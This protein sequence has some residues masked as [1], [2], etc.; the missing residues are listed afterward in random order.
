MKLSSR[1]AALLLAVSLLASCQEGT[2]T[3]SIANGSRVRL[4][5]ESPTIIRVRAVPRGAWFSYKPSLCVVP[6]EGFKEVIITKEGYNVCMSTGVITASVDRRTGCVTFTDSLGNVLLSEAGREFKPIRVDKTNAYTVRQTFEP[7]NEGFYGLGQHQADEWDYKG[8]NEELYQYNTKISIP[9]VVSSKRYGILWDSYSFCRWGDPRPYA[10]LGEVFT[11]RDKDGVKGA[12][13]GTYI[14]ARGDIL[15]RR[16]TSLA[17]EYLRTPECDKVINAPDGFEFEGS[18]VIYEGTLEPSESGF[19]NFYLYYAGY[20]KVFVEGRQVMPEIWR[21]A[22]N[23]NGR[24]FELRMEAGKPVPVRIEWIPDGG[25]SYCALRVLS[26]VDPE[27]QSAMSWWGEMQDQID[28]YFIAGESIDGVIAG[29]RTLTGKSPIVP[30]WAMGYWQSR[31]RYTSQDQIVGTLKE[32]RERHIPIDNIVQDWQYW[33]D[34]GWGS[35]E[36]DRTR[37]PDPKKMVKDIHAMNGRY[38]ISVWP[39]FYVG[40]E[41]FDEL[42]AKGWIYQTAVRD[43]VEDWLGYQ[44]SFYDAYA[45]GARKLFWKQMKRHLYG[46]GVD[47]WWMDASEPNIHDCTDMDY[48]KAMCGPTALG[49]STKYFNAYAL[50]NAQAIYEGQRATHDNRR[51]FLLTRNGF[52]GLQ[53]YSTASW[54]GDI[55]TRWEDMKAQISAGLNYSISGIPFWGQDIG[56]FSVEKRFMQA[57]ALYNSTGR[58]GDDLLEWREMQARWHE[59]GV[60]CPL[61]R[62]HGQWP[63]REPWN[64]DSAG[65]ETYE[66]ILAADRLRYELMPYIYT[67]AARVHFDDYTIMRPLVMD[68]TDDARARTISDEFMFGDAILVCPVYTYK[69]RSRQVYLPAGSDWYDANDGYYCYHGGQT[70]TAA[71]PYE[72]CPRFWRSG[73][74]V[75][76]GEAV[77]STAEPQNDLT[78]LVFTGKNASYSLYEDEGTNYNY[79]KGKYSR[80]SMDWNE[81]SRTFVIGDRE[82]KYKGMPKK[83]IFTVKIVSPGGVLEKSVAYEGAST[84][85]NF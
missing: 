33:E 72:F 17:Q 68:F 13:T 58:V 2:L 43:S 29:Y 35:H 21:T 31:E 80:I 51:V 9:F 75:P 67:M 27:Q 8:R 6:Q 44:Q 60:F 7:Q 71:A 61:Y 30:K 46:L 15:V 82:G 52:A 59:W 81:E 74:I 70:I 56:G 32:F 10:Q 36:F 62:A 1:F 77:E 4:T 66:A 3:V 22:W 40:T 78:L 47:S 28:Y 83:R 54:S 84:T 42:N 45:P 23:P 18:R 38:M 73:Q 55:G 11:L 37:F 26:P 57:Q 53:R 5:A 50:M 16:E 34:D 49:P 85:L 25:V 65:S 12:L 20:V 69:A 76:T 64:I 24:K 41:H 39:K 19:F 48:R 79:E 14:P 63:E